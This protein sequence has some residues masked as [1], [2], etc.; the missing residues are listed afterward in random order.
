MAETKRSVEKIRRNFDATP[1]EYLHSLGLLK[2]DVLG[3]HCIYLSDEDIDIMARTGAT[4]S[5]NP[6]A[7]TKIAEGIAPVAAMLD[8]GVTV[9]LGT[10]TVAAN[11]NMDMFEAMR[12]AAFLQ[13]VTREDPS[14]LPARSALRMATLGGAEALNME[15]AVGSLEAGKEADIVLVNIDSLHMQPRNSI[16]NNLVYCASAA[17][18]VD[19]VLIGGEVIVRGGALIGFD[20]TEEIA[21]FKEFAGRRLKEEGLR[22]PG[23]Y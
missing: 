6:E 15:S 10:D 20:E 19:T 23:Y 7:N 12:L 3:A 18:D 11:D 9:S 8:R 5:H 22:L 1:V 13:K 2:P 4:V 14:V 21:A 16:I 17:A